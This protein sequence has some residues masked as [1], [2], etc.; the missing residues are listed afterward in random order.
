MH[1]QS[2]S[3]HHSFFMQWLLSHFRALVF[4]VGEFVRSPVSNIITTCVIGIAITLPLGF[5]VVLKNLQFISKSWDANLPTI[6]LYLK[7]D[8]QPVDVDALLQ[9]L[10]ANENITRVS[11]ISP[12]EGLKNFEKISPFGDA[13]KLLQHNPIPGLIVVSPTLHHQ[14]PNSINTLYMTLKHAPQVDVAQLNMNW[15]TRLYNIIS[16]GK[17]LTNALSMLLG[18]GVLLIIG[19]TLRSSLSNH[20]KEIQV[21]KLMGAT[22]A[23]IRRPLL[24]RGILYGLLGGILAWICI[25]TFIFQ[26]Q[27]P[28]LQLAQTYQTPFQLQSISFHQ[29]CFI[30]FVCALLGLI[31]AFLITTQFLNQPE[32]TE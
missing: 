26:L 4:A 1:R 32:Q 27:H 2:F 29:G 22:D 14:N 10:R 30:F 24:Y 19:H 15:V 13:L 6:S 5:Y 28:V 9:N 20:T 12:E 23:Y 16:I 21:L 25:N 18:F 31:S 11:Y 7:S 8:I 17:K 3:S